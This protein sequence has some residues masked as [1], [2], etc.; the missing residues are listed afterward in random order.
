MSET[1]VGRIEF[2]PLHGVTKRKGCAP[3]QEQTLR[4]QS[5][6]D[7]VENETWSAAKHDEIIKRLMTEVGMPNS[8]SVYTA[9]HQF[10]N[11]L[12]ALS[13]VPDDTQFV[14]IKVPLGYASASDFIKDCG[15][16]LAHASFPAAEGSW[17]QTASGKAFWPLDPRVEDIQIE[18]IAAA[19]SK[20]CRYG[21]HCHTFYSVAE[22]CVLMA[23]AAPD[24]Q[25]LA[26]LL[27]DASEAYLSDVIRPVKAHLANYKDIEANLECAIAKRFGLQWPMPAEVKHLDERIIADEREQAMIRS[28]VAWAQWTPVAPLGVT[29]QFWTPEKAEFEFLAAFRRYGGHWC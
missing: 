13:R 26:A 11:E 27:H 3:M 29:L 25:H 9:F 1:V 6:S 14:T 10:A 24:G 21:G 4:K 17:M 12:H 19:L 15:F 7:Y 5:D 2:E 8:H 22:H 18:D 28:S 16:D 20:L 23:H